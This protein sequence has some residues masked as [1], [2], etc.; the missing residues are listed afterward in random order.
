MLKKTT[1]T[2]T[3]L[4]AL[5]VTCAGVAAPPAPTESD[6]LGFL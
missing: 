1:R 6:F 2:N 3:V 5:A 4:C